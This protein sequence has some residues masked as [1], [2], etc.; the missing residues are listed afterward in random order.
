LGLIPAPADRPGRAGLR[1][2]SLPR[3][4]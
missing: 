4:R 1:P 2:A 3:L